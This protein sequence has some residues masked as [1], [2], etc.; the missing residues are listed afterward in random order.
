LGS[1]ALFA[2]WGRQKLET[3]RAAATLLAEERWGAL[4]ALCGS[5]GINEEVDIPVMYQM[6]VD[7]QWMAQ[8]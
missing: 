5:H 6:N 8:R 1:T 4:Y 3:V 2:L 7:D